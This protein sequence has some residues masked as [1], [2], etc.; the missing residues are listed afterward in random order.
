[1]KKSA[2]SFILLAGMMFLNVCNGQTPPPPAGNT[3]AALPDE[4]SRES[5]AVGMYL[6]D[7]LKKTGVDLDMDLVMRGFKESAAGGTTLMSQQDM[8][9]A[10]MAFRQA[11][12][13]NHQKMMEQEAKKNAAAGAAFLEANKSKPGVVTLPDGLQYKV[14]TEGTGETPSATDEVSAN[15]KGSL[16]DGTEFDS[17]AKSGHPAQFMVRGVIP[18]WTEALQ[19]MNAGSKWEL[20]IP[21]DLAYGPNGRPPVIGPNETLIFEVE[22]LSVSHPQ[23]PAP[24]Q[25]LTSDII[26]VPSAEEMKNGAKV[27]TIKASDV[28][29]MQQSGTTN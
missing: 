19:K 7:G 12:A 27:E 26:R 11:V 20:Y 29:K 25:P 2:L 6:G 17:S 8:T 14:I 15:Y 1:M 28:Q 9:A 24:H 21:S 3:N 5:Y 23:P 22:L 16:V 10:M 13:A 4:R 18:G